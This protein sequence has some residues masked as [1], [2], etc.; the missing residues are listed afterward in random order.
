MNSLTI[1]KAAEKLGVSVRQ[2]DRF[3]DRDESFPVKRKPY[4][5]SDG[6]SP[7]RWKEISSPP[8]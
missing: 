4:E 6:C 2:V 1:K 7:D 3:V 5:G 8:D